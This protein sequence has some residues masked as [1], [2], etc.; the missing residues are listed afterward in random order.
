MLS[1]IGD[2]VRE[3][4]SFSGRRKLFRESA[5]RLSLYYYNFA[6]RNQNAPTELD[7][8]FKDV[9]SAAEIL[10][11]QKKWDHLIEIANVLSGFMEERGYWGEAL[12]L[13]SAALDGVERKFAN[14]FKQPTPADW[15]LKIFFLT[16]LASIQTRQGYFQDA[17][18]Y[19]TEALKTAERIKQTKIQAQLNNFLS[20]LTRLQG[21]H[22]EAREYLKRSQALMPD[23]E[24]QGQLSGK[25]L[26][27]LSQGNLAEA[28]QIAITKR[29]KAQQQNDKSLEADALCNLGD[30]AIREGSTDEALEAYKHAIVIYAE[31]SDLD[32]EMDAWRSLAKVYAGR[33]DLNE[34]QR[35]LQNVMEYYLKNGSM[36]NVLEVYIDRG[37]YLI[38]EMNLEEAETC[39]QR[40]MEI[41]I[42]LQSLP[43]LAICFYQMGII[44][45]R[46]GD[47]DQAIQ[48]YTQFLKAA[49]ESQ[50]Q[51]LIGIAC[52]CLGMAL[53][54]NGD[55]ENARHYL[56]RRLEICLS[57]NSKPDEA[58]TLHLLGDVDTKLGAYENAGAVLEES[59][60]IYSKIGNPIDIGQ[61]RYSQSKLF[62]EQGLYQRSWDYLRQMIILINTSNSDALESLAVAMLNR[63]AHVP[64]FQ[65]QASSLREILTFV[66]AEADQ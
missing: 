55:L 42:Q 63:F 41:A 35:I 60:E 20:T 26:D 22:E 15:H 64:E 61:V 11:S 65:D 47:L 37:G 40:G 1:G 23:L 39:F 17:E 7:G 59:A 18:Q 48:Q 6:V 28:R 31:N 62:F 14:P 4:L 46:K 25:Y 38:A 56:V 8:E 19:F 9:I 33:G 3:I 49:E 44:K 43:Q 66:R 29:Q 53:I 36:A 50:H 32:G 16:Q 57:M 27:V 51:Q 45:E 10:L 30:I 5:S 52:F 34:A 21:R 24:L 58:S 54:Q 2:W 12:W 13:H